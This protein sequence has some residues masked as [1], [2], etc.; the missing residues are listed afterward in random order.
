LR[1][2]LPRTAVAAAPEIAD[3]GGVKR[4]KL[5]ALSLLALTGPAGVAG[6]AADAEPPACEAA[7]GYV[8]I[9]LREPGDRPDVFDT[10]KGVFAPEMPGPAARWGTDSYEPAPA[11]PHEL[12][13][14][15][16]AQT[17]ALA[18]CPSLQAR[19]RSAGIGFGKRAVARA[20]KKGRDGYF[21]ARVHQVA[22]PAVSADGSQAVLAASSAVGPLSGGGYLIHLVR[23]DDGRWRIAA[24]HGLWVS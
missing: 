4:R 2:C 1:A 15:V 23:G 20:L 6:A 12:I 9:V 8:Q 14:S 22:L 11:P 16:S 21:R 17:N 18:A 24:V 3:A 10:E 13:Q 7:W 5:L 19:L